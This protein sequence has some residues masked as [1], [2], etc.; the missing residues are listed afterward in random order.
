MKIIDKYQ[1]KVGTFTKLL[2]LQLLDAL[3]NQTWLL[4]DA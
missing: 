3:N 1:K 4:I 2:I